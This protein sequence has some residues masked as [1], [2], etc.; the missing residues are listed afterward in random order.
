MGL[1]DL[2][3]DTTELGEGIFVLNL[4]DYALGCERGYK[5]VTGEREVKYTLLTNFAHTSKSPL[6]ESAIS[7]LTGEWTRLSR[8]TSELFHEYTRSLPDP[9]APLKAEIEKVYDQI[10]VPI[11]IRPVRKPNFGFALPV[12]GATLTYPLAV[13]GGFAYLAAKRLRGYHHHGDEYFLHGIIAAPVMIPSALKELTYPSVKGVRIENPD[14]FSSEPKNEDHVGIGNVVSLPLTPESFGDSSS[15]KGRKAYLSIIFPDGLELSESSVAYPVVNGMNCYS[16]VRHFLPIERTL[17]E[18]AYS[19][20]E[21]QEKTWKALRDFREGLT[22][23]K[24][25][26]TL[27]ALNL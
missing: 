15:L 24:V 16:R 6:N 11:N 22:R 13:A 9:I 20:Y 10:L 23:V 25:L 1:Q 19:L 26:A 4:G 21:K 7:T 2:V 27:Q 18:K 5:L 3:K 14:V 8:P 12:I 17:K